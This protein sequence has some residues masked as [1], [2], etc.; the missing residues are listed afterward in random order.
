MGLHMVPIMYGWKDGW[1]V[2]AVII[3]FVSFLDSLVKIRKLT[4][5]SA[6]RSDIL[7]SF[8]VQVTD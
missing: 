2:L 6:F 8:D 1:S 5:N 3:A 4:W 7:D